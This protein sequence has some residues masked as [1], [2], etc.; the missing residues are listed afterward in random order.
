MWIITTFT[1]GK[2]SARSAMLHGREYGGCPEW[3]N[4]VIPDNDILNNTKDGFET[5]VKMGERIGIKKG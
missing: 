5:V 4:T 1:L 3:I 2:R